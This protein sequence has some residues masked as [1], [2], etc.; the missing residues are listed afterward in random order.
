MWPV[1]V[2][3]GIEGLAVE[4]FDELVVVITVG[5]GEHQRIDAVLALAVQCRSSR[6]ASEKASTCPS[7]LR[8]SKVSDDRPQSTTTTSPLRD[9][10]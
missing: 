4:E 1:V 2:V 3:V 10:G 9:S 8:T 5:M 6:H 7:S